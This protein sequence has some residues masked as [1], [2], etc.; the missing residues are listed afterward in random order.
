MASTAVGTEGKEHQMAK[1]SA[2]RGKLME[3]G[4][5]A[6]RLLIKGEKITGPKTDPCS[7]PDGLKRNDFC[8]FDKPCEHAY[9]KGKIKLKAFKKLIEVK[10]VQEPGLSLLNPLEMV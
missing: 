8:D 5:E 9:Q 4:R 7:T 6:G 2:E 1:L 10:I 3:E